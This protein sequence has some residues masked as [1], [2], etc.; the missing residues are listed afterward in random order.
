MKNQNTQ[1]S[2]IRLTRGAERAP[3]Q[4]PD[5]GAQLVSLGHRA[6]QPTTVAKR[7]LAVL[8][9]RALAKALGLFVVCLWLAPAHAS[10]EPKVHGLTLV[11]WSKKIDEDRYRSGRDWEGTLKF[12]QERFRGSSNVKWHREVNLPKV[13]LIH[14]QSLRDTWQWSGLNIYQLPNGEV[15]LYVLK[16]LP[17]SESKDEQPVSP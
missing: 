16:R 14:L 2:W 8:G 5:K 17:S 12:F 6:L 15:R 10:N 11:P 13:K 7:P 1:K 3:Q 9:R 4:Q